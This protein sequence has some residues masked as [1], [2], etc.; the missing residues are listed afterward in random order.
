MGTLF[1]PILA[2]VLMAQFQGG[3]L[4]GTV[5]DDQGK[6]VDNAQVIFR[7][8]APWTG[9][10]EP[11]EVRGKTDDAGRFR[12]TTSRLGGVDII[13]SKVWAYRHGL[14]MTA[15]ASYEQPLALIL[16]KPAPR[17]I[18]I[19]GPDGQPVVGARISPRAVLV[20]SA[21]LGDV[22]DTLAT[23]C[24]VATGPDG[25][26]TL[27][28]LAARDQ[29]VAVRITAESVGTQDFML[30]ERIER[31]ARVVP[32]ATITIRLKQTSRLAGRVRNRAGQPIAD[33]AVEVWRKGRSIL[34]PN[35]V[36]FTNG[37][38]R[39]AADGSFQTPPNL[40]VGSSYRIVVRSPGMEPILSDWITIGEQPRILLPMLQRPLRTI[41]GRVVDR[42]GKPVAGVEVFQSGDGPERTS[43]R[44]DAAGQFTLG[45]FRQGPVFL[46]TRGAGFRFFG[47]LIKPSDGDIA[48]ELTRVTERPTHEMRMLPDPIPLEES[49]ALARRLIQP[50]WEAFENMDVNNRYRI[51][52]SLATGDPI[53][54]LQKLEEVEF[55]N[56]RE[57]PQLRAR[58]AE[59]LAQTDLTQAEAVAEAIGDPTSRCVALMAVTD[60]LT[61]AQRGRK[62]ALLDR[63]AVQ[64]KAATVPRVRLYL[65][66]ELAERWYELGEKE[67]AKTLF[68]EGL[69]L[70]NQVAN[71]TAPLR[72]AFAGRLAHVN[73]PSALA[74]AKEFPTDRSTY[75]ASWVLWNIAFHLAADNPAE[76][77]RVLRQIPQE[78]GR[79]WLPSAIVWKMT[80]VDPG[81][82]RRL[83]E[84]SQRYF[85]FPQQ[86]LFLA[87]GLKSRD[88][89]AALQAFQTAMEGIDRLMREGVGH[90]KMLGAREVMLPLVEQI[91]PAL[92]PE[93]FW[94]LVATRPSVGNPLTVSDYRSSQL[95][96][97]LGWYDRDVAAALFE[98]IRVHMEHSDDL[99]RVG[100]AEEFL[101]WSIFDPRAAVAR[102]EQ[103]PVSPN[104]GLD[105]D[106]ARLRVCEMLGL[107]RR[108][109]PESYGATS[110]K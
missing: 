104:F 20:F 42:Q 89:V 77:E 9:D 44:T 41:S 73:L 90:L 19:E 54:A 64:V 101:G 78:T 74:I 102:L 39:T 35:P 70:A 27:N 82:A 110:R 58:V 57:A 31:P 100:L 47:R 85:D 86:F 36:K 33:Q 109:A 11:V 63:A 62:L 15:A 34:E 84:E 67:K 65:M 43:T 23:P 91:D 28:Y 79:Y 66:A 46:F 53:G 103:M 22:P 61:D 7:A 10:A 99:P 49:R 55:P 2:T 68:A 76:A 87:H 16:Q 18:K 81:R 13:R 50:Y 92:V 93:L 59:A 88:Q 83:V 98:P 106:Y 12:L 29:L 105:A 4:Q 8:S 69:V 95:V 94:R 24:A 80:T 6:P 3:T 56:A 26:A 21:G 97:D 107:S 45:G 25:T 51:L 14:A 32:E 72:G 60:A 17:A 48:V 40:L 38:I 96:A 1:G 5:V 75:S 108:A 71:K 52:R 37:P 30:I